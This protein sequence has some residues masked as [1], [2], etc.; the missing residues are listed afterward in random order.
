MVAPH[1]EDERIFEKGSGGE[2]LPGLLK[3]PDR[4]IK[5]TAIQ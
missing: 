2:T 4:E 1:N 3:G 5:P